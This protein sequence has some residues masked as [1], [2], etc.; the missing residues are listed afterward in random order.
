MSRREKTEF[1][2]EQV[3]LCIET[4]E[5]VQASIL[6]R[7]I[8]TRYFARKPKKAPEQLEKD[9]K[10]K[11]EKER[12]KDQANWVLPDKNGEKGTYN[13]A[14]ASAKADARKKDLIRARDRVLDWDRAEA[15]RKEQERQQREKKEKERIIRAQR[16]KGRKACEKAKAETATQKAPA[17]QNADEKADR[18]KEDLE[19]S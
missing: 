14:R 16:E 10:E 1:I 7:K 3:A 6:S 12:K 19:T 2:L 5:W 4:G 13:F 9:K 8:S 18:S 11:E 17:K 15:E